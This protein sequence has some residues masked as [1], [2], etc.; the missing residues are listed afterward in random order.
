MPYLCLFVLAA[1]FIIRL[2]QE[3]RLRFQQ[4][5]Q[6]DEN[7]V[8]LEPHQIRHVCQLLRKEKLEQLLIF[9]LLD[10]V[11]LMCI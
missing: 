11:D 5:V 10:E 7:C 3:V 6:E 2:V 8:Q 9:L 4:T 1:W